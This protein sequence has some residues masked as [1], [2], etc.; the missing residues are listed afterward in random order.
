[1]PTAS[2]YGGAVATTLA[3]IADAA[4]GSVLGPSVCRDV[5]GGL[6]SVGFILLVTAS[7]TRPYRA[8]AAWAAP[9]LAGYAVALVAVDPSARSDGD[10]WAAVLWSAA[11]LTPTVLAGVTLPRVPRWGAA[12]GCWCLVA[13]VC[14]AAS[15]TVW[16]PN[17]GVGLVRLVWD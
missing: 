10:A 3:I 7:V 14:M 17:A 2:R 4:L 15:G 11:W 9:L 1:M 13:G 8:P 6:W 16:H 5:A 12:A